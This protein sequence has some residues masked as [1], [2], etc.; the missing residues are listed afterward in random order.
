MFDEAD[1]LEALD[2]EAGPIAEIRMPRRVPHGFHAVW[3][4][5]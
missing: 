1:E 4:P 3:I 5:A 2:V